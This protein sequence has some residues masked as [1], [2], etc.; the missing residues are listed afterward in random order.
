VRGRIV[1]HADRCVSGAVLKRSPLLDRFFIHC[2][3][4]GRPPAAEVHMWNRIRRVCRVRP[5]LGVAS[6]AES[7]DGTRHRAIRYLIALDKVYL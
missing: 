6:E 7:I 1:A 2:A 4:L 3:R 5:S